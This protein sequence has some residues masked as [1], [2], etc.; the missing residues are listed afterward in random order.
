MGPSLR[1]NSL[2]DNVKE[3]TLPPVSTPEQRRKSWISE[4]P[5]WIIDQKNELRRL[6]GQLNQTA[7]RYL[8]RSLEF[9]L[10]EDRKL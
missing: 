9:S 3:V 10:I 6:P 8:N 4:A 7:S 2:C 1:L 5:W